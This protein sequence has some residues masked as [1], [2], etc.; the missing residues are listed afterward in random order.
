MHLPD[1]SMRFGGVKSKMT[2]YN[3]RASRAEEVHWLFNSDVINESIFTGSFADSE[4]IYTGV[5]RLCGVVCCLSIRLPGLQA[6][7]GL[8][9]GISR[10]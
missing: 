4:S 10:F 1:P 3:L 6:A 8:E 2:I 7:G 5:L 9:L